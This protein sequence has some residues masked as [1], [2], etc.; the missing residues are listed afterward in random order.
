M[1][2]LLKIKRWEH[3]IK[4]YELAIL[5]G[6]SSTYLSMVENGRVEPTDKF[7][8]KVAEIFNAPVDFCFIRR[9]VLPTLP[10]NRFRSDSNY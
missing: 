1:K 8:N 2:N 9:R 5:L 10:T 6:C 7:K 4:Q 3:G